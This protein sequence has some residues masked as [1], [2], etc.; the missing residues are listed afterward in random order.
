MNGR[1]WLTIEDWLESTIPLC[2]LNI[3]HERKIET[4][5]PDIVQTIFA[6]SHLGGKV[7]YSGDSQVNLESMKDFDFIKDGFLVAGMFS[8]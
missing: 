4:T 8:F 6:S 7:L 5:T 3:K 2:S 1:Q